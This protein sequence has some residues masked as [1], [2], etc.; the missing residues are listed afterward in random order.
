MAQCQNLN[1]F[2]R[3]VSRKK[4]CPCRLSFSLA[5]FA[6]QLSLRP[7]KVAL[8]PSTARAC[9]HAGYKLIVVALRHLK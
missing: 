6:H 2:G 9:L 1:T 7:R 8:L 4:Q 3:A 5:H